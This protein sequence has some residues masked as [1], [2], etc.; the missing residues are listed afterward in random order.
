MERG[1][2]A[3]R[4]ERRLA[5]TR[6]AALVVPM[7]VFVGVC[8]WGSEEQHRVRE[9]A[10]DGWC[11]LQ[12]CCAWGGRSANGS[13]SSPACRCRGPRASAAGVAVTGVEIVVRSWPR[14]QATTLTHTVAIAVSGWP[15]TCRQRSCIE[16][17]PGGVTSGSQMP[18]INPPCAL[19]T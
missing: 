11:V 1:L 7:I 16:S 17:W 5:G 14:H 4:L 15:T 8:V 2:D 19:S 13:Y 6:G 10:A 12:I 18:S 9:L 3:G